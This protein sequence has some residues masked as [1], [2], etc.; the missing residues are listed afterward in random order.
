MS[1]TTV[2]MRLLVYVPHPALSTAMSDKPNMAQM[3]KLSE[4]NL[5]QAET[6][7]KTPQASK[8][9]TEEQK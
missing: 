5:K 8:E 4:T 1:R 9:M 7:E 6:P 3:E 2:L